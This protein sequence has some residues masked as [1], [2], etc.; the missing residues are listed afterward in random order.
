MNTNTSESNL[1]TRP[2]ELSISSIPRKRFSG[3]VC[4]LMSVALLTQLILS[5]LVLI[6][7]Q[8]PW[9]P[10]S[11]DDE[12]PTVALLAASMVSDE[13]IHASNPKLQEVIEEISNT[14]DIEFAILTDLQGNILLADGQL[15]DEVVTDAV[16]GSR[17]LDFSQ[18]RFPKITQSIRQ[19][20]G[21]Q[22]KHLLILGIHDHGGKRAVIDGM[23][24]LAGGFLGTWILVFP[25]GMRC[26][27]R[28]STGMQHLHTAIRRLS[29]G[30]EPD[31]IAPNGDDEI[32][33]LAIA[34]NSMAADILSAQCELHHA[35][36]VLDEKVQIRTEQLNIVNSDL[37]KSNAK[38]AEVTETALRFTS[39]V[40]HEFRTPLTVIK[41][42]ALILDDGL[43]G[44]VN[45][46]QSEFLGL[47]SEATGD[48]VQLVDDFL[49]TDKLRAQ[50]LPVH[51]QSIPPEEIIESVWAILKSKAESKGVRLACRIDQGLPDVYVDADMAQRSLINFVT[52]AIK[53]S[54]PGT[55][56]C[57][58]ALN[59]MKGMIQIRVIDQ[60]PG[61]E[62]S[63]IDLLFDRFEQTVTGKSASCKGFGLGLNIASQLVSINLGEITVK[64]TVG[65]GCT[66]AFTLPIDEPEYVL[67][68]YLKR[69]VEWSNP[70][71]LVVLRVKSRINAH[72]STSLIRT[73]TDQVH[74]RDI[75]LDCRNGSVLVI[76]QAGN[77][78]GWHDSLTERLNRDNEQT[79]IEIELVDTIPVEAINAYD[80]LNMITI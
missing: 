66:F 42:F 1:T 28:S 37:E 7:I 57:I 9:R 4:R 50:R 44:E 32:A 17:Q 11:P 67:N 55:P 43:G 80:I 65:D 72:D 15:P 51:R 8:G 60:G 21:S 13:I 26:I 46:K 5:T 14:A 29:K 78:D 36:K 73:I 12:T 70:H 38:L 56:V 20:I 39:D 71:P 49:D 53:F 34:F 48:L 61:L 47:I 35:N 3:R 52:N 27:R 64:S 33:Y 68:A 6:V 41:E 77:S 45:E 76:G 18:N 10:Y 2:D 19:V 31:P 30:L 54:S 75:I 40:A 69:V 24:A 79:L 25:F 59:V 62:Q 58:E 74:A 22:E 63:D 16:S 23:I